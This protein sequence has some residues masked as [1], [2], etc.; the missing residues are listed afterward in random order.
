MVD[1]V[2]LDLRWGIEQTR[3]CAYRS[4]KLVLAAPFAS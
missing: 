4:I 2:Y 1:S 3:M